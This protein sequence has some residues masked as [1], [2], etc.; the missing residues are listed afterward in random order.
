MR[1]KKFTSFKTKIFFAIVL[2]M[3]LFGIVLTADDYWKGKN[4]VINSA[5]ESIE[6]FEKVYSSE[7][8]ARK[9]DLSMS[10]EIF[11]LNREIQTAFAN[12]DR[13]ALN[14]LTL[15]FFKNKLKPEYGV[16]QFQF[17]KPPAISFFRVHKP[18]KHGDDLSA[19]RQTVVAVNSTKKSVAGLEAGRE[20][21]GLRIVYPVIVDGSHVGSVEFG[22]D[23]DS[24]LETARQITSADYAVGAK[25]SI[26][27]KSKRFEDKAKDLEKD[28][29]TF[30][31]YSDARIRDLVMRLDLK[32]E[33]QITALGDKS[34]FFKRVAFK[35]YSGN[36]I[37]DI[38]VI[39]DVT[40]MVSGTHRAMIY[41]A[42]FTIISMAVIVIILYISI[43]KTFIKPLTEALKATDKLAGGDLA[44]EITTANNDEV[45]LLMESMDNMVNKLNVAITDVQM[46]SHNVSNASKKLNESSI[47]IK[48]QITEQSN[49]TSGIMDSTNELSA[50]AG[51]IG[52]SAAEIAASASDALRVA[53]NGKAIVNDTVKEVHGIEA[54]VMESAGIMATLGEK[55]KQ[56]G[57]IIRVIN[58]IADQ[59]NLLAL[60][61][62]IEAARAGEQGRGFA[63]VADEV[64]KLAEKTSKATTEIGDMIGAIQTETEMA[65]DSMK[66]SLTR[67][68]A[69]V[70][71]SKDSGTSLNNIV[72]SVNDLRD[73]VNQI[74]NSAERMTSISETMIND[75]GQIFEISNMTGNMS[76]EL[77][78]ASDNLEELSTALNTV[79]GQFRLKD[80]LINNDK[81]PYQKKLG[82]L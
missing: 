50:T 36:N 49:R 6:I 56:I 71:L 42:L 55:S 20:G 4:R 16:K 61:A 78:T 47:A 21:L 10:L 58:D 53:T 22:G 33:G 17:H 18:E 51:Q 32:K 60:N 68:E 41:H 12:G 73:K 15:D 69:G 3:C 80:R 31:L 79:A 77:G 27:T 48:H 35:D 2:I 59:T 63:V 40:E 19:F 14:N 29:L 45:G 57:E 75:I 24:I 13:L 1:N 76:H 64:R 46:A 25:S 62:A 34:V 52:V 54:T 43:V 65:V 82:L 28:G 5:M 38:L 74:L 70:N 66:D 23:I 11:L 9:Q 8:R 37:G 72:E 44:I 81:E 26:F 67:I 39:K 30:F 7:L